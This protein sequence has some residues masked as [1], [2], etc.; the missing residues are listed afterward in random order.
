MNASAPSA[1]SLRAALAGLLGGLPPKQAAQAVDRLIA[2][3]RGTTPTD[4]P[5]LRDRSDV[6]AYAAY[7]MPA[8]FEAVRGAL[9]ARAAT[10][11]IRVPSSS[12]PRRSRAGC[13]PA[14]RAGCRGA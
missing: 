3:Y 12:T 13:R 11:R 1:D 8:T 14:C 10:S 5:V 9:A 6:A 7:R 4:A 2:N